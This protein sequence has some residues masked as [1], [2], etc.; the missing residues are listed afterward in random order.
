MAKAWVINMRKLVAIVSWVLIIALALVAAFNLAC[1]IKEKVTGESAPTVF[2]LGLA[3]VISPSMADEINTDDLVLFCQFDDYEK[4]EIITWRD[5]DHSVTHRIV[6]KETDADGVVWYTTCGDRN[7]MQDAPI[8]KDKIA[9]R[10]IFVI[11]KVGNL[12]AFLQTSEGIFT[13][14]VIA[15]LLFLYV[16]MITRVYGRR[17]RRGKRR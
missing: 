15:I 1:Y 11:P 6:K 4:D 14:I 2:G 12:K 8:T 13:L 9:G 7:N 17:R 3:V 5:E 16:E 10:V